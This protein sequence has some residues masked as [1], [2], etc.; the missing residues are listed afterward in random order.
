MKKKT[1]KRDMIF[2]QSVLDFYGEHG[3]HDLVWRKHITPYRILV[4]EVMLQQTQ[5]RRVLSK[6]ELWNRLYPTLQT[7]KKASLQEILIIWQGL[8]YQRRAKS[9]YGIAQ[10][11][12]KI[13]TTFTNLCDLPGVGKYTASAICAFAYN[14]FSYPLLETNIRTALIEEYHQGEQEIHDGMLYD[15]LSRLELDVTVQKVGARTWYYALMDYGASLKENKIS[16]NKK[17]VH[18]TKQTIYKGSRRELRA[19]VLFAIA[20][21]EALPMDVRTEEVVE[22]LIDEGYLSKVGKKYSIKISV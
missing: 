17:S 14:Q 13:P 8:G 2:I 22:K 15:D 5:V 11:Y 10:I 12:T 20:H 6:F 1:T 19:K 9:L 4:S 7:L 3:R 16:H 21:S 18:Y